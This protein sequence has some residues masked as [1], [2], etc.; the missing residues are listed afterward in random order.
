MVVI[1]EVGRVSPEAQAAILVRLRAADSLNG[2]TINANL[3]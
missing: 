1:E 3:N 2:L